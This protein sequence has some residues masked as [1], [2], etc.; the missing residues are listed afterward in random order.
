M[1]CY[2]F[3]CA[4]LLLCSNLAISWLSNLLTLNKKASKC[5]SNNTFVLT[6]ITVSDVFLMTFRGSSSESLTLQATH[7]LK[8]EE[9]EL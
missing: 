7:Y 2:G 8:V 1:T 9:V 4:R 3:L 6:L 5:I